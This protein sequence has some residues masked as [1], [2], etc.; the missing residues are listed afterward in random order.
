MEDRTRDAVPVLEE[1]EAIDP[2]DY[3]SAYNL[4][5]AWS[6]LGKEKRALKWLRRSFDRGFVDFKHAATDPDLEALRRLDGF[7]A[8]LRE[9]GFDYRRPAAPAATP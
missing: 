3:A 7:A 5:C 8:L 2:S 4:A 1:A 6:I 9:R